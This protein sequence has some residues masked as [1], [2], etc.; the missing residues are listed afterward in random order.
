VGRL[1]N[2]RRLLP[3]EVG[4]P[5]RAWAERHRWISGATLGMSVIVLGYGLVTGHEVTHVLAAASFV[6]TLALLVHRSGH[7]ALASSITTAALLSAASALVHFSG[8]LVEMHFLFFITLGMVT[9]YQS[10]VPFVVAVLVTLSHH[11]LVGVVEPHSVYNHPAAIEA[12]FKWALIHAGF[13][14]VGGIVNVTAWR[15]LE[16]PMT[17]DELTGLTAR[18]LLFDRLD[19][20]LARARRANTTSAVLFADLVQFKHVNDSLGHATG[21]LVLAGVAGRLREAVRE[22][23]TVARFGGDEFVVVADG[24]DRE[25]AEAIADRMTE[26]LRAPLDI[27]GRQIVTSLSIGVVLTTGESTVEGVMQSADTAMYAAKRAGDPWRVFEREM[28]CEAKRR[29]DVEHDL[30]LAL[31]KDELT[32]VYQPI[33]DLRSGHVRGVEALVRWARNGE[34][35][36]SPSEFVPIAEETGLVTSIDRV[37]LRQAVADLAAWRDAHLVDD[38]FTLHVNA[39][40]ASLSAAGYRAVLDATLASLGVPGS[41]LVIEVTET[42]VMTHAAEI[43]PG[44]IEIRTSGV[45]IAVDDFGTGYSSLARLKDLPIDIIKI[46]KAFVDDVPG[47]FNAA[48]TAGILDVA[49]RLGL[50]VIIEGVERAD[51]IAPLISMG[52]G[53]AQGF[54]L[55][56]PVA[57]AHVLWVLSQPEPGAIFSAPQ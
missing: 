42:A 35:I 21:D 52:A 6:A 48:V 7:R 34:E 46:D 14:L 49:Q 43:E 32:V 1:R 22:E 15:L 28:T 53:L 31:A 26:S 37:V 19:R 56:R 24:V 51:Q 5:D 17:T 27:D 25:G 44:L 2:L 50:A 3:G 11:A 20:S 55:Y 29:S 9:L 8:G 47:G 23:D 57:P 36:I 4:L 18:V 38:S 13:V 12:P 10:W 41:A 33:V 40:P 54:Q 39:S 45:R 16:R 30:R